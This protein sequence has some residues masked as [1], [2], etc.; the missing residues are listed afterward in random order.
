MIK[1]TTELA[2]YNELRAKLDEVMAKLKDPD[3]DVDQTAEL[4]EQALRCIAALEDYLLKAENRIEK[5]R[6]DWQ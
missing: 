1:K 5:V 6:V 2:S 4:Y 3:C